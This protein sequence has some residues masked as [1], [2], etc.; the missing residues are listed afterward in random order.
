[1]SKQPS[2][3]ITEESLQAQAKNYCKGR[4]TDW[5]GGEKDEDYYVFLG[6]LIDFI[7]DVFNRTEKDT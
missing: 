3:T 5:V 1:M 2:I 7:D 4:F 6:L